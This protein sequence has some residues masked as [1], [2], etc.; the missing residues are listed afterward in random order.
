MPL[1]EA[2]HLA[3]LNAAESVYLDDELGSLESGKKA[4]LLIVRMQDDL[5]MVTH[6]IVGGVIVMQTTT[7]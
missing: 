6:S 3:T 7:K 4:D 2:V 1:H 5:P